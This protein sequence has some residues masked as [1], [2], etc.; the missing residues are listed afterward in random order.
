MITKSASGPIDKMEENR[1]NGEYPRSGLFSLLFF[2]YV[3]QLQSVHLPWQL[4]PV[5]SLNA[6]LGS[7]I[8]AK[9][10]GTYS[11]F[12][13]ASSTTFIDILNCA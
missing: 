8:T 9:K 2:A 12:S 5:K 6:A 3:V 7:C 11:Y 13:S 10:R 1:E 4:S